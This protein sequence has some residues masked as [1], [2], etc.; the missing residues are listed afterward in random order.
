MPE[1][2][3]P[4]VAGV[5][6]ELLDQDDPVHA[7]L[8]RQVPYIQVAGRCGCGCGTA[9]FAFDPGED[10]VAPAPVGTGTEVPV[11]APLLTETGDCPGGVMIVTRRGYLAWLE[12]YSW[13]DDVEVTL[14]NAFRWLRARR[15]A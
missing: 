9:D 15:R 3:P 8:R 7:A 11:E 1:T 4:D 12:V 6:A 5:L 2:L 10:E 14:A 13:S